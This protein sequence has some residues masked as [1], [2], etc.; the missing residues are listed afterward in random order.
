MVHMRRG[1]VDMKMA[2]VMIAGG[3]FGSL[4]GAG[5]FRLLQASGQIDIVIGLLFVLILGSIGGLMLKDSLTT[6]GVITVKT[7][8]NGRSGTIAGL[9]R[10]PCVG[11]STVPAFTSRRS[12]RLCSASSLAY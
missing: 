6:L 10:C 1:G 7:A 3:L 9:P 4:V 5:L 12:R 8:G 2:G 11:A